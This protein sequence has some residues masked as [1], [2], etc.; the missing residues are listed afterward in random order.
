VPFVFKGDGDAV[1][2]KSPERLLKTVIHLSR[3]F[4]AQ[5]GYDFVAALE[6]LGAVPPFRILGIGQHDAFRIARVP[7]IF[8]GLNFLKG[9][10]RRERR[11]QG[12]RRCCCDG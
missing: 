5:E 3:P 11:P 4:A 8:G 12:D 6:E 7:E 10:L 2:A 1:L 9:C